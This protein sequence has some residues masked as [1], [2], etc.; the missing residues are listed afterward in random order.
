MNTYFRILRYIKPYR[1]HLFLSFLFLFF[2]SLFS[3]FSIYLV[4][5][6]LEALFQQTQIAHQIPS[7]SSNPK[8]IDNLENLF[9][10]FILSGDK[11]ES[12]FHICIVVFVAFFLKAIFGYAQAFLIAHIEQGVI[13]DIRNELYEHLH[14]LPL[15]YFTNERSGNLISRVTNDVTI[16]N[17]GLTTSLVSLFREPLLIIVFLT[18]AIS[19]SWQLTLLAFI[20]FPFALIIISGIGIK[21]HKE[22]GTSQ[23]RMAD[24]TSVLQETIQGVKVVKSFAMESFESNKFKMFTQK[25]FSSVRKISRLHKLAIPTTELLSITAAVVIIWY[26]GKQVLIDNSISASEFIGFVLA[27]FQIM[28]PVK[29]LSQVNNKIQESTAAGKRL[30]EILDIVPPI[31]NAENS[32]VLKNFEKE[33]SLQNI[34]FAYNAT[35]ETRWIL[36]DIS[37]SVNKGEIVA[38]VGASGSGK[39]TLVD[40]IPRFYDV[41][42]GVVSID[43]NDIRQLELKSLRDKIGIV[44][45][46]TILFNDSIRNNISYGN[47]NVSEQ[48]IINAAKVANAHNFISKIPTGY[49][50]VIGDRGMKLSGGERQR[51]AIARAM[52]KNPPILILDEATSA[53]DTESEQLVQQAIEKLMEGRT[54]I[55]IAHRLSTI[56]KANRIVVLK[57]GKIVEVGTHSELIEKENG[58]YKRLYE[59]Q[60]SAMNTSLS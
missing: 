39:T 54:T 41:Q 27:I 22:S 21:L 28:P 2:Y 16:I 34:S 31:R 9:Y 55:V 15:E 12:L 19:I 13:R 23:E 35:S 44:T 53:L 58:V 45:Q 46:E 4:V 56:Q 8:V 11:L 42:K 20:I 1:K 37:L 18:I 10:Q 17:T 5:P 60:F 26:G 57:V 47:R 49:E 38:V 25:Y 32:I 43:G 51:I 14:Q 48:E 40:L 50:T 36:K 29:E 30:F 52:L 24:I 33:I 6:L 7:L 3:G 59:I